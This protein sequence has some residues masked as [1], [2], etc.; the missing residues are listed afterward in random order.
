M[1]KKIKYGLIIVGFMLYMNLSA[2]SNSQHFICLESEGPIPEDFRKIIETDVKSSDFNYFLRDMFLNGKI[3]YGNK[4]NNYVNTVTDHLLKEY[5]AL[6]KEVRIYILKSPVVNAYATENGIF[7][8]NLGLLAQVSN[9]SELAF[10]IAHEISHYA[11]NH[12]LKLSNYKDKLNNKEYKDFYLNYHNRSREQE[13]ES[14]KLALERY[15][16]KSP[17]SYEVLDGTFDVLQYSEL[18]FDEI[19]FTRSYVE[20]NF[21]QFPD[22]YFLPSTAPIRS[23]ED[24]IDTLQT[25]PNIEKRRTNA[26]LLIAGNSNEG[27]KIFV[28]PEAL[29]NEIRQLAR[30]ECINIFLTEHEYDDAIYNTYVLQKNDPDN[31]F[32]EVAMSAAIYGLSK[33]KN[34]GGIGS[35]IENYKNIEGEK[36]QVHHFFSRLNRNE[37]SL[38]ALRFAWKAHLK[39]PENEYITSICKDLMK[40]ISI[41]NKM[42][43]TSF[44]DYPMGMDIGSIPVE[45]ETLTDTTIVSNKYQRIKQQNKQNKVIPTDKFKTENFMLVDFRQDENFINLLNVVVNA[46]EDEQVHNIISEEKNIKLDKILVINPFYRYETRENGKKSKLKYYAKS[47]KEADKL[48][49]NIVHTTQKL[50][51]E[52]TVFSRNYLKIFNT[53]QYNH[54]AKLNSWVS[55]Y[56]NSGNI[57]MVY[58]QSMNIDSM[59]NYW[60]CNAVNLITVTNSKL[61]LFNTTKMGALIFT[62]ICPYI[63]PFTFTECALPRYQTTT[64]FFVVDVKTGESLINSEYKKKSSMSEAYVNAFIYNMYYKLKK[65]K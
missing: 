42:G 60:G 50:H 64:Q 6:R 41:K 21:Y 18:P 3:L 13:L 36:Q 20:T 47:E 14:D 49:S 19:P 31:S 37:I 11:E 53:E 44:S 54:Y 5:P 22:N 40:D 32:L 4:L 2:Q 23:R 62:I 43:Y 15:F 9:E 24:Y 38:L 48:A 27:R 52:S 30:F 10:I 12:I 35:T 45:V 58:Y 16:K 57:S 65:G 59:I 55:D 28:Q 25:H 17:Y 7:L 8:I 33:H 51:I 63:F 39:Q 26:K 34:Y 56:I 1:I 46:A 61:R 29:F